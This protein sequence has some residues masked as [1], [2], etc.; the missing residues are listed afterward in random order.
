MNR[1]QALV[2]SFFTRPPKSCESAEKRAMTV[3]TAS[4]TKEMVLVGHKGKRKKA[5]V[6][7]KKSCVTGKFHFLPVMMTGV[8]PRFISRLVYMFNLSTHKLKGK[9]KSTETSRHN[10]LNRSP[11]HILKSHNTG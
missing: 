10:Y 11:S 6:T 8:F 4:I 9:R 3:T 5:N 1:K 2:G 7:G